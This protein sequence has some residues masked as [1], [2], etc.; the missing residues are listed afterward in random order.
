[1]LLPNATL[2]AAAV[3][4]AGLLSS[5]P[6]PRVMLGGDLPCVRLLQGLWQT[7][8]GWGARVSHAAAVD[9]MAA[10]HALGFTT[11]DGADHYGPAEDLMGLLR[12]RLRAA[13]GGAE[14]DLQTMTKW[15][16][17][18]GPI[19]RADADAAVSKSLARMRVPRLDVL[20]LHWWA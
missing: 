9:A 17:Q 10:A 18:P 7:S 20:Q 8:G 19:S 15:C 6:V 3:T 13:G 14:P 4:A 11:F 12:D 5:S 16:P 1:M 2:V